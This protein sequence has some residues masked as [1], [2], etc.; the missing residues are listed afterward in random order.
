VIASSEPGTTGPSAVASPAP[1]PPAPVPSSDA[2][3]SLRVNIGRAAQIFLGLFSIGFGVVVLASP[4]LSVSGLLRLVA[5]S[6]V[7]LSVQ[8]ILV[9]GRVLSEE[10]LG[11]RSPLF[12]PHALRSWGIVGVGVVGV[13]LAAFAIL[14]PNLAVTWVT[15]VLAGA[16]V[17]IGLGRLIQATGA[18]LPR[19]M[20]G[21]L[22]STGVLI[23]AL[24]V[25]AATFQ[26]LTVWGFAILVGIILLATGIETVVTGLHPTDPRQFVLLKLILFSAFYGLILINWIDLYGK[27]VPAYG[28]WLILTYMAPFGVLIVFEGWRSWPLAASLGLLVS[29]M[30]DVGYYFIGNLIFG[31]HQN[32]GPWIEGQLGLLG[33]QVVT[34]F[35]GG[36]FT[37]T[38]T[39]WMMGATIYARIAVVAAILYYWWQHPGE[40]VARTETPASIS[41]A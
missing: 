31:F 36:S 21:S 19:W 29:L 9:G 24:I 17:L 33:N 12:W 3:R 32:L 27:S 30:N 5:E 16:I 26:A 23:V 38:V 35:E 6:V 11:S 22:V 4:E 18:A 39:S 25:L 20:R 2:R 40:I 34:Y 10:W 37:I 15:F 1:P 8:S 28:I 14:D 7:I 41:P 13:A